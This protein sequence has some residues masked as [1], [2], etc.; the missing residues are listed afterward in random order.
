MTTITCR[1]AL[2]GISIVQSALKVVLHV[3][4]SCRAAQEG[5]DIY[6]IIDKPTKKPLHQQNSAKKQQDD[7]TQVNLSHRRA[8]NILLI[9]RLLNQREGASPFCLLID[10]LEQPA[11]PLLQEYT[12]RA[13]VCLKLR[14]FLH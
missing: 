1:D 12:R 4:S 8:H 14:M 7:M 6:I 5:H 3:V 11:K 2:R 13:N 9:S 10:S